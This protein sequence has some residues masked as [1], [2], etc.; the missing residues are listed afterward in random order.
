MDRRKK[1]LVGGSL[2]VGFI[3]GIG[4]SVYFGRA[5][6]STWVTGV[7]LSAVAAVALFAVAAISR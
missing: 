2:V 6:E 7:G 1:H 3:V 4:V 5:F